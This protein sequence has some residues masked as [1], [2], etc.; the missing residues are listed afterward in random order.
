M[1]LGN[2]W[3]MISGNRNDFERIITW[4]LALLQ[5][6]RVQCGWHQCIQILSHAT[7][8]ILLF[9]DTIVQLGLASLQT[10]LASSRL[11]Q[12][13]TIGILDGSTT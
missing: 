5:T 7:N 9:E 12:G 3:F 6:F 8:N 10:L 4:N 13:L 2:G 1:Q 11:R